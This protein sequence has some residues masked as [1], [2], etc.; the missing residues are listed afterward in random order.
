[1]R[2]D[3]DGLLTND[4]LAALD[5]KVNSFLKIIRMQHLPHLW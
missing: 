4:A 5:T 1:M 2:H 3:L